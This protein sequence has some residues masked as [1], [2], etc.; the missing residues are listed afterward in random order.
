MISRLAQSESHESGDGK[1]ERIGYPVPASHSSQ[2]TLEMNLMKKTTSG[3]L[4]KNG[5]TFNNTYVFL[6][7]KLLLGIQEL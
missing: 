2:V 7:E 4:V 6:Y 1:V 3:F 5:D